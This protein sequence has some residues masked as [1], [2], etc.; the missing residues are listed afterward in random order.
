MI[1]SPRSW[2]RSGQPGRRLTRKRRRLCAHEFHHT[3]AR[4]EHASVR[5]RRR[6][7]ASCRCGPDRPRPH[8][9]SH[10]IT[11]ETAVGAP[12]R[13]PSSAPDI[14]VGGQRPITNDGR[15]TSCLLD[16]WACCCPPEAEWVVRLVGAR[17]SIGCLLRRSEWPVGRRQS[18]DLR[19]D[20]R[21]SP[22]VLV[23]LVVDP[24]DA[25]SCSWMPAGSH[26]AA[27]PTRYE[28]SGMR[29]T[30]AWSRR[31]RAADCWRLF[32]C[33]RERSAF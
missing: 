13:G 28:S 18:P 9:S 22:F 11:I 2:D 21:R 32:G 17:S 26:R 24:I 8:T 1:D 5:R 23:D 4:R 10:R 31:D 15:V 33:G 3:T 12:H 27:P 7:C 29:R 30:W 19:G 16:S 6:P 14:R 20:E 25:V